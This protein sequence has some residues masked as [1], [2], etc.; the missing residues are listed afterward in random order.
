MDETISLI[1]ILPLMVA[2][3]PMDRQLW[4]RQLVYHWPVCICLI[5]VPLI[6]YTSGGSFASGVSFLAQFLCW[7]ADGYLSQ[8]LH[9]YMVVHPT[10]YSLCR[11]IVLV[12][13]RLPLAFASC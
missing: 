4:H 13:H 3:M 6:D 10:I 9:F 1:L 12:G 11:V 5:T 7:W 2:V 8:T